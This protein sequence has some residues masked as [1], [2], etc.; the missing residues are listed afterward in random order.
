[1]DCSRTSVEP[2]PI[3]DQALYDEG[4]ELLLGLDGDRTDWRASPLFA[5]HTGLPPTLIQAGGAEAVLTDATRLASSMGEVTLDVAPG[6]WHVYQKSLGY[7][8]EARRA[9][10]QA[11]DFIMARTAATG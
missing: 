6:L 10:E 1:V 4:I 3:I 8:P 9:I 7:M 2:D 5:D 11:A